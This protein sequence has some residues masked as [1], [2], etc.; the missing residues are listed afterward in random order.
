MG[1]V[2]SYLWGFD[3]RSGEVVDHIAYDGIAGL[4]AVD[5]H[6]LL[7]R[8]GG[9]LAAIR[10]DGSVLWRRETLPGHVLVASD[11][12]LITEKRDRQLACLDAQVGTELW[13]FEA[14]PE[15]EEDAGRRSQIIPAGSPSVT[16]V[17]EHVIVLTMNF[18]VIILSLETGEVLGQARAPYPGWYVVTDSSV[19]FKQAF[20]LSEFDHRV[21]K[22]IDRIEYRAEV[23]PLYQG[24]Q[25]SV[26]AFCISEES[27]I[28]TTMHGALMGISRKP[29]PDGER[30][31]WCHEV[32]GALMPLAEAP[33]VYGDHLYLTKKGENPELLCFK[34]SGAT[35][36][37]A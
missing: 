34:G 25:I 31:T 33:V 28:W 29:G 35:G 1:P 36:R 15:G 16:V 13:R 21:L 10:W 6:R 32:P 37:Y 9:N 19:F 18:R 26:N 17:G 11:R 24:K 3:V 20:G 22:E 12:V 7:I 5:S 30:V 27:V 14:P 8:G 2:G 4:V 23:E